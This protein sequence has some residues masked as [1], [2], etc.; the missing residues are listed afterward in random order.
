MYRQV[1]LGGRLSY[2]SQLLGKQIGQPFVAG[3]DAGDGGHGGPQGAPGGGPQTKAGPPQQQP[4]HLPQGIWG[5]GLSQA[6]LEVLVSL[7]VNEFDCCRDRSNNDDSGRNSRENSN[8]RPLGVPGIEEHDSEMYTSSFSV[9]A[10]IYLLHPTGAAAIARNKSQEIFAALKREA[11]TNLLCLLQEAV[12]NIQ[13]RLQ[14]ERHPE[15]TSS[16]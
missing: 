9:D 15:Q 10:D 14:V 3:D 2:L 6:A 1:V 8:E 7:H 16:C 13:L 12:P 4:P 11:E 5:E